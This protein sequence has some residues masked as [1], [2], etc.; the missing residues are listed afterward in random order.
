MF[1]YVPMLFMWF[2]LILI[3]IEN[4]DYFNKCIFYIYFISNFS[5]LPKSWDTPACL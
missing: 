1:I 4:K 5:S 2:K 3:N